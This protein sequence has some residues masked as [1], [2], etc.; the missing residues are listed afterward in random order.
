VSYPLTIWIAPGSCT[1]IAERSLIEAIA[2]ELEQYRGARVLR[3]IGDDAAVVRS[4]PLCVTSVDTMVDGV[5]FRLRD[6]WMTAE[7]VGW[8]CLAGALSDIAAM[9]ADPGEAYLALA[10]PS[11]LS[12]QSALEILEGAN[13]LARQNDTT[14]L[15]GDVVSTDTLTISVTVVGWAEHERD[16]LGRDG[17]RAGDLIGVTGRLGGAGAGLALLE[18]L[19][20]ITAGSRTALERLRQPNPRLREGRALAR[21]GAHA[22]IDLSDGLASDAAH[23]GR[24]SGR[25][26]RITLEHLPLEEGLEAIAAELGQEPWR[27]A[28]VAGDDYELCVCVPPENRP[29]VEQALSAVGGVSLS[30]IGE[31]LD[32]EPGVEL[33]HA[34]EIQELEGFEHSW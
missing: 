8:R 11:G 23:L 29:R 7:Q 18:G 21:S 19:A 14:I 24:S 17:A 15:G 34:G 22:M 4:R 28:A 1:D 10:V 16:L 13:R 26:L 5:H 31:V 30:W 27:L 12:K 3:G 33:L 6:G 20:P 2:A 32:G 25:R 9:G